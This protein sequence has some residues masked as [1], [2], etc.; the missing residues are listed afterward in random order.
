MVALLSI[1]PEQFKHDPATKVCTVVLPN[2]HSPS[3][4][5]TICLPPSYPS[6][7]PPSATITGLADGA[8]L[9]LLHTLQ[10]MFSPGQV[11][12]YNWVDHL[13]TTPGAWQPSSHQEPPAAAP[14][15]PTPPI[16]HGEPV[17]DRKSTFQAHVATVTSVEEVSAVMSTLL[18]VNKLRSATHNIMA[19]RIED[20]KSG[21]LMQVVGNGNVYRYLKVYT[22]RIV[23]TT[24]KMRQGG[25]CC[26]FC[27]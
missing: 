12:L 25:G 11:V 27:R 4:E 19:Y 22:S 1:F 20:G 15:G 14:L 17:T 9:Q 10:G 23:M 13:L 26:T 8:R 3:V 7:D 24:G 2:A 5:I 6:N 21:V 18:A 16:T